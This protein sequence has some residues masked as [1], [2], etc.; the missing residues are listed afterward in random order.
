MPATYSHKGKG[1]ADYY[2]SSFRKP[3]PPKPRKRY[4]G[5]LEV[6]EATYRKYDRTD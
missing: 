1:S 6:D 3:E 5:D 2:A 4:I